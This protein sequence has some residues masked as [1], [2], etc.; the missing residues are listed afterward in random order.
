MK[1]GKKENGATSQLSSEIEAEKNGVIV[2][3]CQLRVEL[4]TEACDEKT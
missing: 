1:S 2:V 3:G 4:C